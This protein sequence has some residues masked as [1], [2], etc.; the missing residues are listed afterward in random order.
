MSAPV[1]L[2]VIVI[3]AND[4]VR[5]H[6]VD[7]FDASSG[8][9]V[10]ASVRRTE[11]G[12]SALASQPDAVVLIEQPHVDERGR[13]PFLD[14]LQQINRDA[15]VVMMIDEVDPQAVLAA[16]RSGVT[17]II[18]N[19]S[20]EFAS[21][22][23]LTAQRVG[24]VD[25]SALDVLLMTLSDLPRNPLSARE[26]DVLSCLAVG[27]SNAEAAAKLFVSRETIKSHVAHVLRKLEVEDRFAAV[28]KAVKIGLLT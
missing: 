12:L 20:T 10:I 17:S 21:T 23:A 26:R 3:H 13:A 19:D 25:S 18:R 11:P 27:L 1:N 28:D 22:V 5:A 8:I 14:S 6:V 15:R 4:N 9:D 7:Q 24:V 16:M 2:P